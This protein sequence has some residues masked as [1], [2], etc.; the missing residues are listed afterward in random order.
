MSNSNKQT[1]IQLQS[2]SEET[3]S[4]VLVL[5]N[6]AGL[7]PRYLPTRPGTI[8]HFSG[9]T[10]DRTLNE[11]F[12][13]KELIVEF[14]GMGGYPTE[15][16]LTAIREFLGPTETS[17]PEQLTL[18]AYELQ[19]L[20]TANQDDFQGSDLPVVQV[21]VDEDTTYSDVKNKLLDPVNRVATCHLPSLDRRLFRLAV[22]NWYGATYLREVPYDLRGKGKMTRN[23]DWNL[24]MYFTLKEIHECQ[25][26]QPTT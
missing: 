1:V 14:T 2:T 9:N 5:M 6:K 8:T 20:T 23:K 24:Y 26:T 7:T 22:L 16:G 4:A 25:N 15:Q 3:K 18:V 13:S 21:L 17:E 12:S 19:Y 10:Y 11:C